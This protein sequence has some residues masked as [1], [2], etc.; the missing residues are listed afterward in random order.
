MHSSHQG[1]VP[2]DQASVINC[3]CSNTF[4]ARKNW[5]ITKQAIAKLKHPQDLRDHKMG[6]PH[7]DLSQQSSQDTMPNLAPQKAG[8]W[9]LSVEGAA[10]TEWVHLTEQ[11]G[12]RKRLQVKGAAPYSK[13]PWY[14]LFIS[15]RAK[16][17]FSNLF[18]SS[19]VIFL[20]FIL[21]KTLTS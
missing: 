4:L 21:G 5:H 17:V 15:Q 3:T 6:D 18:Q 16:R 1:Q 2:R 7:G 12:H 19:T 13:G 8:F 10:Q 14:S 11:C 20:V 9:Q